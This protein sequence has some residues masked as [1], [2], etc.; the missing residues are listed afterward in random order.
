ML[1][2]RND[3]NHTSDLLSS[4]R[5][6]ALRTIKNLPPRKEHPPLPR[7][8]TMNGFRQDLLHSLGSLSLFQAILVVY[9]YLTEMIFQLLMN[10]SNEEMLGSGDSPEM[11][12]QAPL[13]PS[14]IKQA[15]QLFEID[16]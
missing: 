7:V 5:L 9:S 3:E 12:V 10:Q 14:L 2:L 11:R 15:P 8:S 1:S 4:T 6:Q 13:V 16:I